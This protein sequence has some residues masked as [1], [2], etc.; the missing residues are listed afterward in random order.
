MRFIG[1]IGMMVVP[2]AG[3]G[4]HRVSAPVAPDENF[5]PRWH[6]GQEWLVETESTIA[7]SSLIQQPGSPSSPA[8][9]VRWHFIVRETE[10]LGGHDCFKAT[11]QCQATGCV[12]P[13]CTLWVDRQA[14][15]L[16]QVQTR[17]PVQGRVR[18]LTE[19]YVFAG[20]QGAPVL[21]PLPLL[22]LDVPLPDKVGKKDRKLVYETATGTETSR[23]RGGVRFA[24]EVEQQIV[25]I[26]PDQVQQLL[27]KELRETAA[28]PLIEVRLQSLGRHPVR[29]VWRHDLPWPLYSENGFSVSRLVRVSDGK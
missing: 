18:T 11:V 7:Q 15:V 4:L 12:D 21:G 10:K 6:V 2:L 8:Q 13:V 27:A 22:P 5:L 1:L 24:F 25:R 14:M 3:I 16:R 23:K 9:P 17:F 29:Q 28:G 26:E 20:D 19:T